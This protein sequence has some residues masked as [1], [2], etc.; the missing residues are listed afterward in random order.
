MTRAIVE[1]HKVLNTE[2]PFLSLGSLSLK[3]QT[4]D[5]AISIE[6]VSPSHE[7]TGILLEI[8]KYYGRD[9][10]VVES[11]DLFKAVMEKAET[12]YTK[13]E[14]KENFLKAL[15]NLKHMGYVGDSRQG[16]FVF[17][18]HFFGKASMHL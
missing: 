7:D 15:G 11:F 13:E 6:N 12:S 1:S 18:K 10:N 2:S 3:A 5:D 8:F 9:I 14:I 4:K 16:A 17:K